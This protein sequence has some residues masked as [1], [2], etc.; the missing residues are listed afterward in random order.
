M[1]IF[2]VGEGGCLVEND[3]VGV[4]QESSRNGKSLC[5]AA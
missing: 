1:L 2:R 4:L 3:K 5:L